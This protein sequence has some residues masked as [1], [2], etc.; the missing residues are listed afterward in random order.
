MTPILDPTARD[1]LVKLCGLLGSEHAGERAN[2]A[3]P[4]Q[5]AAASCWAV[6]PA[7]R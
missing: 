5:P 7:R 3:L 6:G 1:R 4:L 2:A